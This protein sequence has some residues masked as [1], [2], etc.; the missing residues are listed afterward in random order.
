[1][2]LQNK[3]EKLSEKVFL[4]GP[5]QWFETIG[6][7]Q[8]I[9]LLSEGLYPESK[10]L[11]IGCGCLRGGYWLIH[12]LNSD[13]YFGIEPNQEMLEAGISNLLEPDLLKQKQPRFDNNTKFDSSVFNEKFDFFLARSIWTHSSK[14]NILTML[15]AFLRDSKKNGIFLTSVYKKRFFSKRSDYKGNKWVGRSH[16]CNKAGQVYHSLSWVKKQCEK[17]GLAAEE[18][19][20]KGYNYGNQIWLKIIRK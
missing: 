15:K 9:T 17:R 5:V 4:G 7:L 14:D 11:D 1:M 16:E 3:A 8:L 18:I 19:K 13:C 6:R 10:I 20:D 2:K 12:F